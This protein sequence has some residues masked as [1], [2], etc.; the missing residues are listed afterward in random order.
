MVLAAAIDRSRGSGEGV[1]LLKVLRK[2]LVCRAALR[3]FRPFAGILVPAI[4]VG[5]AA[6]AF[7]GPG[8]LVRAPV[9]VVRGAEEG[10]LRVFRGIPYAVPPTGPL[11]WRAPLAAPD[12][13]GVR[14]ATSFGAA[15]VQPPSRPG[16]IY[17][18]QYA[19]MSE[20]C[21]TLNIWSPKGNGP[22]P[23][24]LWIHGGSLTTGAGSQ[25][26]YDG[27]ALAK[28]GLVVVTINYRLGVLGYL[29]H[30]QLSAENDRHLSGNY[31]LLD[32][33][34][35][36]RW[37]RRNIGAFGGDVGNVTIA[38]E[39]AGA[40]SVSYL[41]ASPLARGLF[42]KAIAESAYLITTPQLHT[43]AFGLSSAEQ[44]GTELAA[45]VGAEDV[46]ALRGMDASALVAAAG[47]AGFA[48]FGA[49][50]GAVLPRQ[51]VDTFD[52]GEQAPVPMIA[53][54]NTGEIRSLRFL[55]GPI[56]SNTQAYEAAIRRGYG[57]FADAFLRLYP[58]TAM[59]PSMLATTGEAM[60]GWTARRLVQSQTKLG[61]SAYAYAFDHG[62]PA[63][64][65]RGLHAFHASEIPY[66]FD[67]ANRTTA[68]WPQAPDSPDERALRSAMSQY[69]ASFARNGT[70]RAAGESAWP[71]YNPDR[72][73]YL[74]ITDRP[75]AARDL[76]AGAY[77]IHEAVVCRRRASGQAWNWNVGVLAPPLA[78]SVARCS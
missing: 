66:V 45:K 9:G 69:W 55:L 77:P 49:V 19:A 54:Y 11:R 31:G 12:W 46:A 39:S 20:D 28:L 50:D 57:E 25:A 41:M 42:H 38:G 22:H 60:Y 53:G 62:Y 58:G 71:R 52:R 1:F 24:L 44:A 32:Q 47:T 18:E 67:T 61:L 68:L 34:E 56:P 17:F 63:A 5:A 23:V 35:A 15:C 29:A 59:E 16:S 76:L 36:L 75:Y 21:L 7:G 64:D 3:A 48:P 14:N 6:P 70:P 33:I 78:P 37:V 65:K 30:P 8:P 73:D 51:L 10:G 40:L 4:M 13:T 26:M 2:I 72:A 74:Q 27:S 43:P